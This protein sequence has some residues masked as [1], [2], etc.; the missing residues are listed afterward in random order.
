ML[1]NHCGAGRVTIEK[2]EKLDDPVPYTGTH[3]PIRHDT[4]VNLAKDR[5]AKGGFEIELE[6]YS[7]LQ[8]NEGKPVDNLFGLIK[9]KSET[10]DGTGKI[11]G[12]RNS[13]SMHFRAQLG[14]G[15]HVIVCDNLVFSA[16]IIVGRKHT[17]HIHRDLP[18]QMTSAVHQLGEE[19][20][21]QT[22]RQDIYKRTSIT[23][24]TAHHIMMRT[25]A[26]DKPQGIP[27]S[28]LDDWRNEYLKPRHEELETGKAWG[29]QNAFTEIAKDWNFPTMQNRT[30]GL[31]HVM[32]NVLDFKNQYEDIQLYREVCG[33]N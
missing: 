28:K 21:K 24:E 8:V 10:D 18:G 16:Q 1:M 27:P 7:L 13:G 2:L 14:C 30:E 23:E 22:A 5:L 26:L 4:F 11:V 19:F 25:M 20:R 3:Y 12:L 6:E 32:D 31:I 17:K 29:L 15:G 33:N 9:L